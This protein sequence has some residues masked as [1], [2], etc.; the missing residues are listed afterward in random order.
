MI[1][2]TALTTTHH[3]RQSRRRLR[4]D[5]MLLYTATKNADMLLVCI[6]GQFSTFTMG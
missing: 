6:T 1:D 3:H 5:R 4:D 2:S